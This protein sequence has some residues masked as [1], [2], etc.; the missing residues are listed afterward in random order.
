M[1]A[2]RWGPPCSALPAGALTV[3]VPHLGRETHDGRRV[4]VV[5]RESHQG[6]EEAALAAAGGGVSSLT[7]PCRVSRAHKY[8][9]GGPMMVTAHSKLGAVLSAKSAHVA[10]GGPQ[11]THQFASSTRPAEKP[12]IGFLESS[13]GRR[14][15][16]E[17]RRELPRTER[18]LQLL[19]QQQ[20][21]SLAHRRRRG[22]ATAKVNG[23]E[24]VEERAAAAY[25]STPTLVGPLQSLAREALV[26][27]QARTSD[28][29]PAVSRTASA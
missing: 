29:R 17:R 28:E 1:R 3:G 6:V 20:H 26:L 25:S 23:K 21:A 22:N 12:S 5:G 18:T 4:R 7:Q 13:G 11:G 15:V 10:S 9:S 27:P 24:T 2:A 14:T 16:S 19:A 8:V